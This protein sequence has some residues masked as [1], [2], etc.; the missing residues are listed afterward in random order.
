MKIYCD[1]SCLINPGNGGYAG[2]ILQNGICEYLL[3]G[4]EGST[5]NN[6]MELIGLIE[7]IKFIESNVK[8]F[9]LISIYTDSK[10]V[11]DGSSSWIE[12]WSRNDWKTA[13]S[14]DV[15]NRELWEEIWSLKSRLNLS[16]SWV[17]AH[18]Y[19]KYNNIADLIAR[20]ACENQLAKYSGVY[21]DNFV[22]KIMN[23]KI[24][25]KDF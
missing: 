8:N 4:S 6:C 17:K 7:S 23:E 25:N 2:I 13:D 12:K 14:K 22:T 1:G 5:T 3:Y 24:V 18:S 19:H 16:F 9:G 20:Y 21:D 11:C 15:K 10:Y